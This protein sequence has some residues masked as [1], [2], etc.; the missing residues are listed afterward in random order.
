MSSDLALLILRVV[1]GALLFGHGAQKLFGWFGGP[2]LAG[3]HAM[4]GGHLRMRPAFFWAV[5][6]GLTEAGGGL[7]LAMGL[8]SPLGALAIMAAMLIALNVHWPRIWASEGGLEY[9]LVLLAVA[10]TLGITG[11]GLYSLDALWGISLPAPTT[12]LVGLILVLVGVA[13]ALVTRA[14]RPAETADAAPAR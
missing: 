10:G 12:F 7:L 1:A 14:P 6:A 3:T 9:P 8:L 13:T 2:G 4:M 5:M 11:P